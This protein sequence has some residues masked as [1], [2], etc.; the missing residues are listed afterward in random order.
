MINLKDYYA[1]ENI[2]RYNL[3]EPW[4][5]DGFI[6]ATDGRMCIRMPTDQ[7]DTVSEGKKWP[8]SVNGF[9]QSGELLSWPVIDE[10]QGHK[11][12]ACNGEGHP[13][14]E[15]ELCGS[16]VIDY[17]MA[18]IRCNGSGEVCYPDTIEILGKVFDG[19]YVHKAASL[20]DI[21]LVNNTSGDL[22]DKPR[23]VKFVFDGGEET[24]G[25]GLLMPF[26]FEK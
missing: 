4:I 23:S 15:C 2:G 18:C 3:D 21:K 7:P 12:W 9:E 20:P 14:K 25:E 22:P 13:D 17:G 10:G 5:K 1:R 26:K 8:S 11:C 19:Y 6:Y 16:T 24:T